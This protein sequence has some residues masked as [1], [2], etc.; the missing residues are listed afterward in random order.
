MVDH[1][2]KTINHISILITDG[3]VKRRLGMYSQKKPKTYFIPMFNNTILD[4]LERNISSTWNPRA[5]YI[6]IAESKKSAVKII[7]EL[8]K[9]FVYNIT[10]IIPT[11]NMQADKE[12]FVYETYTWRP[13]YP[14]GYCGPPKI[15]N[16]IRFGGTMTNKTYLY[17]DK[18]G[19]PVLPKKFKNCNL[20][21]EFNVWEPYFLRNNDSKQKGLEEQLLNLACNKLLVRLNLIATISDKNLETIP[22][23]GVVGSIIPQLWHLD[24]ADITEPYLQ[25]RISINYHNYDKQTLCSIF[26]I[27]WYG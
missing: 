21:I 26:R 19:L 3:T 23:D 24:K 20:T 2:L 4:L 8:W 22:Y 25:V 7:T 5:L 27:P 18:I 10:V 17:N 11:E 1:I 14:E 12:N 6:C 16:I 15:H 9:K 13:Y